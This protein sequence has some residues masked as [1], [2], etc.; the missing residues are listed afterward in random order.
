MLF[1]AQKMPKKDLF[2]HASQ[3]CTIVHL[4]CL[5]IET[6]W[7]TCSNAQA[8]ASRQAQCFA[9]APEQAAGYSTYSRGGVLCG[10]GGGGPSSTA[11][12]G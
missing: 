11:L 6:C 5:Y 1:Y 7:P 12:S 4:G 9:S 2:A 8:P 3:Y 10:F